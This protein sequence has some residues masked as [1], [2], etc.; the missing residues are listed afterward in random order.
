MRKPASDTLRGRLWALAFGILLLV[1]ILTAV[2]VG[3][4]LGETGQASGAAPTLGRMILTVHP[5][6]LWTMRPNRQESPRSNSLGFRDDEVNIDADLRI[7]LLGD[8]VSWGDGITLKENAFPHLLETA[9][10]GTLSDTVIDLVN[11]SMPGYSTFQELRVLE[12][13]GDRVRPDMVVLQF[14]LNDVVERYTALAEYGGGPYF[15]GLDTR[16]FL[17]GVVGTV[18]RHSRLAE[19]TM[20][21]VQKL[22]RRRQ[23]LEVSTMAMATWPPQLEK[24]WGRVEGEIDAIH[25]WTENRGIP[26]LL[27]VFPY[28]S[29]IDDPSSNQPQ[30]RLAAFAESR[31]I[32]FV[33]MLKPFADTRR[34]M[35]RRF[36]LHD[37]NHL[38]PSGHDLTALLLLPT[39]KNL[40]DDLLRGRQEG[41]PLPAGHE[42]S[43][44]DRGTVSDERGGLSPPGDRVGE[45]WS[46]RGT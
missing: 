39:F 5:G 3:L 14:C 36:I 10:N 18:V 26:L 46:R 40:V 4:R 31:G 42:E 6:V 9:L 19:R 27:I 15:M 32:G 38:S 43:S 25:R 20:R 23:A 1:V 24:A 44:P 29:Q 21:T 12:W 22:A 2:E 33:D 35:G 7:L 11:L 37:D 16:Q 41:P 34:Q 28:Q 17:Q 8:S 30:R 13:Y 45:S